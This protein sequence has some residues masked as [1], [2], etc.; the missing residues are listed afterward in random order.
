M[1]AGAKLGAM[2]PPGTRWVA[3]A[4]AIA[5]AMTLLASA[6]PVYASAVAERPNIG[7]VNPPAVQ[8][9]VEIVLENEA[10]STVLSSAPYQSYLA[11]TYAQAT[12]FYAA[13]HSSYPNYLA[14]TSGRY[15]VCG[16]GSVPVENATNLADL[17]EAANLT[18]MGYFESMSSPCQ[19]ATRGSYDNFH[20]PFILYQDIR[21]N[22]SRCDAHIVNSAAFNSS[23]A[24]GTLPAFSYYIPN[25][26][27]DCAKS[28]LTVCDNWLRNFLTPILNST[29]PAVRKLAASTVFFI[30][31]DE[32]EALNST[33]YGGYFA[34]RGYVNP[35][36]QNVTGTALSTC[37]GQTYAVAISPWSMHAHYTANA[38]DYNLESTVEWLFKLG[39]DG[40]WDGTSAFPAMNGLFR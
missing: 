33:Y 16:G 9:V 30:V 27:D 23:V 31:Y 38:S 8:H 7:P 21:Y 2:I 28:N 4:S 13:C 15:F 12:H 10:A 11:A 34:G 39:N 1:G 37:G 3:V 24:N 36:C 26:Y 19:V 22:T 35:W 29:H 32:G 6:V 17:L 20:N 14:M 25:K 40:G 5:V 18:W